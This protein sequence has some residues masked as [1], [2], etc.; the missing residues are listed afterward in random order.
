M[1]G[2][3]ESHVW[4]EVPAEPETRAS[5]DFQWL[6]SPGGRYRIELHPERL[7]IHEKAYARSRTSEVPLGVFPYGRK[8]GFSADGFFLAI[9]S[10]SMTQVVDLRRA[11]VSWEFNN[12]AEVSHLAVFG[13]GDR[14]AVATR[15][16]PIGPSRTFKEL[17]L[18]DGRMSDINTD[19]GA[20]LMA[21]AC[22]DMD[23][24]VQVVMQ[25]LKKKV[26][27]IR[28]GGESG[29]LDLSGEV[30]AL[31]LSPET[32]CL[33]FL[34]L[35]N[36]RN[37]RLGRV[38]LQSRSK[39][40]EWLHA[41]EA[42]D[43]MYWVPRKECYGFALGGKLCLVT[44]R[45]LKHDAGDSLLCFDLKHGGVVRR[46]LGGIVARISP[47][48]DAAVALVT[49]LPLKPEIE[50]EEGHSFTKTDLYL[51][52]C[53]DPGPRHPPLLEGVRV[54][55]DMTC[56]LS[57][58]GKVFAIAGPYPEQVSVH[59]SSEGTAL[60]FVRLT[61]EETTTNSSGTVFRTIGPVS[62]QSMMFQDTNRL[63]V[64]FTS[65]PSRNSGVG[66]IPC[67]GLKRPDSDWNNSERSGIGEEVRLEA[68]WGPTSSRSGQK[69]RL[70]VG[71]WSRCF[72]RAF[73]WAVEPNAA[74]GRGMIF[75]HAQN[76]G[77]RPVM[78]LE[79]GFA[80]SH[81]TSLGSGDLLLIAGIPSAEVSSTDD[82]EPSENPS[83]DGT[84]LIVWNTRNG[85]LLT[86]KEVP[87]LARENRPMIRIDGGITAV[88]GAP[89]AKTF[90]VGQPSGAA[91]L[92]QVT[93]SSLDAL[94]SL[95]SPETAEMQLEEITSRLPPPTG[96]RVAE[97]EFTH[98]GR[99]LSLRYGD[100]SLRLWDI[101][102][103]QPRETPAPDIL[104]D[105]LE[106]CAGESMQ[107]SDVRAED[108]HASVL[109]REEI[110][111]L[112]HRA[113]M[114][115]WSLDKHLGKVVLPVWQARFFPW[116]GKT[117]PVRDSDSWRRLGD[118][119]SAVRV[120]L[121]QIAFDYVD[122]G[123]GTHVPGLASRGGI[124]GDHF[125]MIATATMHLERGRWNLHVEADDGFRVLLNGKVLL[126]EWS[127]PQ[128]GSKA[129]SFDQP[130]DGEV[131]WTV[132]HFENK[133]WAMMVFD[134][135]KIQK[136][137]DDAVQDE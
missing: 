78:M 127:Y 44:A 14:V 47:A 59:S 92:F 35:E 99:A 117:D 76:D 91:R 120:D 61:V 112:R 53:T 129:V 57:P 94:T 52:D 89:D 19:G 37:L 119:A 133:G 21:A 122:G 125:G 74:T 12:P 36:D 33:T 106:A 38:N 17:H 132:E 9:S 28:T 15:P 2:G 121:N 7:V 64:A 24:R 102:N 48:R 108:W 90:A 88:A 134:L 20:C 13:H 54:G 75:M 68:S 135:K 10:P 29:T 72:T 86:K 136:N 77:K 130:E 18:E 43:G 105:I 95:V 5:D 81:M 23:V 82:A 62:L 128:R 40:I 34:E 137:P 39:H 56:A 51:F 67:A 101:Q 80:V 41:Y 84:A 42:S 25:N 31:H 104:A 103:P 111:A 46:D 98:Q 109:S 131:E 97:M 49:C 93:H 83:P 123:P 26:L 124:G 58:D 115:N 6:A 114:W 11:R 66:V 100:G 65:H 87:A 85:S 79:N 50:H 60:G 1:Y 30:L 71:G 118:G 116:S 70:I 110:L 55:G 32:G 69:E 45:H 27:D 107:L 96:S 8:T 63:H 126:E 4:L 16:L 113:G 3:S 73:F 22:P